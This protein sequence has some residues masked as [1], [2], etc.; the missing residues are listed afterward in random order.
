[1]QT[2]KQLATKIATPDISKT[3]DM[4]IPIADYVIPSVKSKGEIG[5]KVIDRKIIQDV[6]KEIPIYPDPVYRPPPKPVKHLY[7]K[8]L[9]AYWTLT[10][11]WIQILKKILDFKK[12]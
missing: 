6:N 4:A 10:Q 3:K 7:L 5:I 9:E 8:F 11:K 12:G 2:I 1:M